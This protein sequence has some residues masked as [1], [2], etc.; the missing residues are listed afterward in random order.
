MPER[1]KGQPQERLLPQAGTL[2]ARGDAARR[3]KGG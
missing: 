3:W 1:V 2:D